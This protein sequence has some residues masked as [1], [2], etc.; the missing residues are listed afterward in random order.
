[1]ANR[2]KMNKPP[3]KSHRDPAGRKAMV[4]ESSKDAAKADAA[5][6]EAL[7]ETFPASDPIAPFVDTGRSPAKRR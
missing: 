3:E 1:M 2:N 5:L 7:R 6:E 4:A